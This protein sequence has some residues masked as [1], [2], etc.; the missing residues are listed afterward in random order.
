MEKEIQ[1]LKRQR[2]IAQSHIENMLRGVS[3]DQAST[4]EGNSTLGSPEQDSK[5]V[6]HKHQRQPSQISEHSF[7]LDGLT[8]K[9]DVPNPSQGWEEVAD[10]IDIEFEGCCK[11][12]QCIGSLSHSSKQAEENLENPSLINKGTK[13]T[14][15]SPEDRDIAVAAMKQKIE[16]LQRTINSLVNLSPSSSESNMSGSRSSNWTRSRSCRATLTSSSFNSFKE[17]GNFANTPPT[18]SEDFI[19]KLPNSSNS[20]NNGE[21]YRKKSHSPTLSFPMEAQ[22]TKDYDVE[23]FV[24]TET[25]EESEGARKT[26]LES[27]NNAKA[28]KFNRQDSNS[29]LLGFAMEEEEEEIKECYVDDASEILPRSSIGFQ[30]K[31]LKSNFKASHTPRLSSILSAPFVI[32]DSEDSSSDDTVSVVNSVAGRSRV[33]RHRGTTQRSDIG[34]SRCSSL[35]YLLQKYNLIFA[36]SR[37]I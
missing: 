34:V 21:H 7:L 4:I 8:P 10:K 33:S 31:N 35:H 24:G 32:E 17:G 3:E 20:H 30:L 16:E 22:D 1:E 11:E 25:V 37:P 28:I 12:V 14:K 13:N 26:V 5:F 2:D 18:G 19:L 29:T 36:F 9:F 15:S 23:K 27:K 6:S